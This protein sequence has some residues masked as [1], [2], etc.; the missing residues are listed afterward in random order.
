MER[1]GEDP[2]EVR[3]VGIEMATELCRDLLAA[4]APGLHFFTLNFS[5]ATR[6]IHANLGLAPAG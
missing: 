5:T 6:E 1:A 4:G 3:A 2:K